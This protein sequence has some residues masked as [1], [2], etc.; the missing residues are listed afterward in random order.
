MFGKVHKTGY[1][2]FSFSRGAG[3]RSI[4]NKV[5]NFVEKIVKFHKKNENIDGLEISPSGNAKVTLN[6][7]QRFGC[8]LKTEVR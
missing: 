1:S 2:F 3:I 7:T 6:I 8:F 5:K 4:R